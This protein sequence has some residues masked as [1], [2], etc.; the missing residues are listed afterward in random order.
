MLIVWVGCI[1]FLPVQLMVKTANAKEDRNLNISKNPVKTK[2]GVSLD[3]VKYDT[4]YK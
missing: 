4:K 2:I 1:R 3:K